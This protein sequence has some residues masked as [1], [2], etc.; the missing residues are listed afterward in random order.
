MGV[1]PWFLARNAFALRAHLAMS[2]DIFHCHNCQGGGFL[3]A[4]TGRAH[5]ILHPPMLRRTLH[6][7]KMI[8]SQ[9]SRF[10]EMKKPYCRGRGRNMESTIKI[11]GL[12]LRREKVPVTC[13]ASVL[14]TVM[15]QRE[16][17]LQQAVPGCVSPQRSGKH[18]TKRKSMGQSQ[19]IVINVYRFPV[20]FVS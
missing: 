1:Q 17:F 9:I 10:P 20:C 3:L 19:K 12:C 6:N 14:G 16:L 15:G 4:S 8:W 11:P 13:S 18:S 5:Y 7:Q 2:G